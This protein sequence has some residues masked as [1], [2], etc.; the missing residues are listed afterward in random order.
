MAKFCP[1]CGSKIEE[2]YKFC[3]E[4]GFNLSKKENPK[5]E[6]EVKK[7]TPES[8]EQNPT[9]NIICENCGE[10]NEPANEVCSGCGVKL[11]NT[12][13]PKKQNI[14]KEEKVETPRRSKSKPVKRNPQKSFNTKSSSQTEAKRKLNN[15]RTITIISVGLGIA[16]IILFLSGV[17]NSAEIPNEDQSG[18]QSENSGVNLNNIQQINDLEAKIKNNPKDTASILQLAHLKNDSHMF[19]QAIVNYKE[20]L[21]L[22]P[23]DPDARIDMGICYYNLQ[24]YKTAIDEMEE[25]LKYDPKHQIGYLDLGIVNLT[26][27]N[28]EKSKE[29]LKKAVELDPNS[30]YGKKA[31]ELLKSHENTNQMNGG[32]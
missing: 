23:N 18:S 19:E 14:P 28:F 3:P 17:F 10:E 2:N 29:N 11:K 26:A 7:I 31:E 30:E 4:C 25:A 27:G 1:D 8:A 24:N 5:E 9:A 20:Y 16:V 32:K 6:S 13:A 22:V 12:Q 15:I 21:A